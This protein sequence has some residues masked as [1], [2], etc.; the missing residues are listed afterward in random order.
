M[1][2]DENLLYGWALAILITVDFPEFVSRNRV[3]QEFMESPVQQMSIW[4]VHLILT[5]LIES[6]MMKRKKRC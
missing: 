5:R 6:R 1:V 2:L 3:A 4:R